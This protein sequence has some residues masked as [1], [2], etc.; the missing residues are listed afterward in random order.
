MKVKYPR[1]LTRMNRTGTIV[2]RVRPE[3]DPG[4]YI[5]LDFAPGQDGFEEQYLAARAGVRPSQSPKKKA[6]AGV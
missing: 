1:L 2:C 3:G 6:P 4:T 5:K